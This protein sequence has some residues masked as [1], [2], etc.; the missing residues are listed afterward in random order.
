M[1]RKL[2]CIRPILY[3]SSDYW[4]GHAFT[5][6]G[7]GYTL[8][9]YPDSFAKVVQRG[10]ETGAIDQSQQNGPQV[11][12]TF[13]MPVVF[14]GITSMQPAALQIYFV[15]STLT[16]ALSA[17]L[18]RTP[19]IRKALRIAPLPTPESKAFWQKVANGE[20][21]M[22]NLNQEMK[23]PAHFAPKTINAKAKTI[24]RSGVIQHRGLNVREADIPAHLKEVDQTEFEERLPT[25]DHDFH[26]GPEPGLLNRYNWYLR[27]YRYR[28]LKNRLKRFVS[29]YT[30]KEVRDKV[31]E[32]Q[33]AIK[34]RKAEEFEARRR[35]RFR[36]RR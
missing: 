17:Q 31:E 26:T 1:V 21:P 29:M 8:N 28:Y 9:L 2:G 36:S 27:N 11:A 10:G 35:E 3:P 6:E 33:R 7:E 18:L 24:S 5:H 19:S 22:Q 16:G 13:V 25:H 15:V 32:R 14:T 4:P 20:I 34:K 30:K 12:L 23:N